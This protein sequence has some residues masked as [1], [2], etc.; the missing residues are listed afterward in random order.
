MKTHSIKQSDIKKKW[1]I[2]DAADQTLG[3][4]ATEVARVLRGK[5]KATFTPHL[6]TGDNVIVIKREGHTQYIR[7]CILC[8]VVN[9]FGGEIAATARLEV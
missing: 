3:R 7:A 8:I 2:V 9:P 4:L 6:D 5:H 1:V